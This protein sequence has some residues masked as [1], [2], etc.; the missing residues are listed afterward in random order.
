MGNS[1]WDS[2][3]SES[4]SKV[5]TFKLNGKN[6]RY[7]LARH[8]SLYRSAHND[9]ARVEDH[10]GYQTPNEYTRFQ[11]LLKS[12][13]STDIRIVS[14]IMTILGD[15]VK[16]GNFEQVA[17]VL[18][19][20]APIRKNDSS[21]NEHRIS[22]VNDEGSDD[23]KQFIGYKGFNKVD[24]GS[25]RVELR[26]N[27]F[28]E[29]KKLLEDQREEL[30]LR[31]SKMSNKNADQGDGGGP[32]KKQNIEYQISAL[33]THNKD[34]NNKIT[35]L[36]ATVS[37]QGHPAQEPQNTTVSNRTNPNLVSIHRPPT[38]NQS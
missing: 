3:V 13:E 26:Y 38:Q 32:P 29:Y 12:I 8:I 33:E 9:M 6:N 36:L 35:Q 30:Q 23:N 28:K 17:D 2:I 10:I 37:D 19:L 21:D 16:R 24:K 1:K 5:L 34:L 14:A 18:V 22:A 4:E 27:S 25:Y 20:S 15:T 31:R 7:K 11:R